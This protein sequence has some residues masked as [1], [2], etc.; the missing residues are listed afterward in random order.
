MG[1][2]GD[3]VIGLQGIGPKTA[4]KLLKHCKTPQECWEVVK[5]QYEKHRRGEVDAITNMRLVD[6]KQ[7]ELN[8]DGEYEVKLWVP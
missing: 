8:K 1:D 4:K 5:Y 2:T 7:L 3:N 6:M